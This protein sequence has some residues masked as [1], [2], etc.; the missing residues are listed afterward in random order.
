MP[1]SNK[2]TKYIL[3]LL[4]GLTL[5]SCSKFSKLLKSDDAEVK[6][7]AAV[8]YYYKKDFFR[9]GQL[10]DDLLQLYRGTQRA[11]EVYYYYSH[12]KYQ[13]AEIPTAAFH[14]RNFYETYPNSKYAEECF[15]MY[16]YCTYIEAYPYNLDPTYT[17]KAIDEFQLFVNVYP[18]S[19]YVEKCNQLIDECRLRLQTKAS[20]AAKLYYNIEDYKA[21]MVSY[22]N[23]V[24]DYPDLDE[25]EREEAEYIIIKAA[26]KY[27]EQSIENKQVERYTDALKAYTSYKEQ[28]PKGQYINNANEYAIKAQLK[29]EGFEYNKIVSAYKLVEQSHDTIS[30]YARYKG[31]FDGCTNYLSAHPEGYYVTQINEY[32]EKAIKKM[33]EALFLDVVESYKTA[34]RNNTFGEVLNTYNTYKNTYPEGSYLKEAGEYADK[35]K[36]KL[37]LNK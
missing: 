19:T 33:E 20:K 6:Y 2:I 12:C 7:D 18:Q 8:K 21:A 5:A 24:R 23:L 31:V 15:Y 32:K 3:I 4:M 28:Y 16:A 27:A 9:A 10:F 37:E 17:Y 14:F 30:K 25:N 29:I 22:K 35:A 26:Y 36:K 11:E 13:M 1:L 34:E